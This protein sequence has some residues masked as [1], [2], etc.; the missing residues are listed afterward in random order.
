MKFGSP[1]LKKDVTT[2]AEQVQ[3]FKKRTTIDELKHNW[4]GLKKPQIDHKMLRAKFADD[5]KSYTL[6]KLDYFRNLFYSELRLS[7][8]I[9]ISILV[10]VESANSFIAVWFIPTVVVQELTAAMS[11]IDTTFFQSEQILEL[12]LGERAL[13]QRNTTAECMTS[14]ATGPLSAFT[15]VSIQNLLLEYVLYIMHGSGNLWKYLFSNSISYLHA[16]I[17]ITLLC[18]DQY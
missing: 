9:S 5:P 7:E 6:E 17:F 12:S 1:G 2:Y 3:L 18:Q 14:S 11:Q 4:P 8:F 16:L 13:Y 15:H 10:A